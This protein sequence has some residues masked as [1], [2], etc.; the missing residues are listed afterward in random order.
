MGRY[1]TLLR[2]DPSVD[3]SDLM[4]AAAE[5]G[6]PLTLLDVEPRDSRAPYRHALLLNRPDFHVAWRG[7]R[8]PS[9]SRALIDLARGVETG[10][11][12]P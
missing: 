5:R 10:R 11:K 7:D 6:V 8:V 12:H 1:Y 9:D 4:Y 3:V 2:F